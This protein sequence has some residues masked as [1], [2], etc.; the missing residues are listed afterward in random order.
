MSTLSKACEIKIAKTADGLTVDHTIVSSH[1]TRH[2]VLKASDL[3]G[4]TEGDVYADPIRITGT[5][6][7]KFVAAEFRD[8]KGESVTIRFE[9]N[10]ALDGQIVRINGPE[11]YCRRLVKK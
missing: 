4:V 10:D 1:R 5:P 2:L 8:D 6:Q 3:L 9:K 7:G 11:A